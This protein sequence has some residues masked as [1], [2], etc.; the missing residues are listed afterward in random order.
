MRIEESAEQDVTL[1]LV[2][3]VQGFSGRSGLKHFGRLWREHL[4]QSFC[5]LLILL[6]LH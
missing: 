4:A 6:L 2:F 3:P 5:K 1:A